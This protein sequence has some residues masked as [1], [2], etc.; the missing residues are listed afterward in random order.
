MLEVS[1]EIGRSLTSSHG[2][3]TF[4]HLH[5]PMSVLLLRK[6]MLNMLYLRDLR[7]GRLR[8]DELRINK[9]LKTKDVQ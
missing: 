7:Q 6:V 5:H 2:I 9:I 4:T 1:N 3:Q 8:K